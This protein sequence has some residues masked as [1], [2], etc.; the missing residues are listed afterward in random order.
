M[1]IKSLC[2]VGLLSF[3]LVTMPCYARTAMAVKQ[4]GDSNA[5]NE[6]MTGICSSTGAPCVVAAVALAS[7]QCSADARFFQ[8]QSFGYSRFSLFL[9]LLSAGFTGVGASTTIANAKIYSTLGGTT[10]M[11]AA[12]TAVNSD[13]TGNQ[14]SISAI[15]TALGKIQAL[16]A[17]YDGTTTTSVKILAQL[18]AYV[19]ECDAAGGI[20]PNAAK[21]V[22]S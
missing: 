1:K 20:S 10:G 21:S 11:G 5:W 6:L 12:T 19:G 22:A 13:V 3:Q 16:G 18:P 2:L 14:N 7:Q 15:N 17:T 9:I 8:R 4:T